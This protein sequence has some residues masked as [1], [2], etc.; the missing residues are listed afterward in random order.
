MALFYEYRNNVVNE[1]TSTKKI[2]Q[3]VIIKLTI[4]NIN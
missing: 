4:P 2:S 3:I 1:T